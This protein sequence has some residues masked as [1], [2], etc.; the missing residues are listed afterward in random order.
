MYRFLFCNIFSFLFIILRA[1]SIPYGVYHT[2]TP[3]VITSLIIEEYTNLTILKLTPYINIEIRLIARLYIINFFFILII[4]SPYF[5][6]ESICTPS[7]LIWSIVI[8]SVLPILIMVYKLK[9]LGLLIKYISLY[10][11]GV[12]FVLYVFNYFSY[13]L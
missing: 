10:F 8:F 4:Y 1:V 9:S 12:N 13:S 7:I 6:L 11:F 2:N 3:N 5:S